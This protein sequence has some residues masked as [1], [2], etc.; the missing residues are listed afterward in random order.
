MT[1]FS[2]ALALLLTGLVLLLRL[3]PASGIAWLDAKSHSYTYAETFGLSAT[4]PPHGFEGRWEVIHGEAEVHGRTDPAATVSLKPGTSCLQWIVLRATSCSPQFSVREVS[5]EEV[6]RISRDYSEIH[7]VTRLVVPKA[8][9]N[10]TVDSPSVTLCATTPPPGMLGHWVVLRGGASLSSPFRNC[11]SAEGLCRGHNLFRYTILADPDI[12]IPPAVVR[13]TSTRGA[14]PVCADTDPEVLAREHEVE[15]KVRPA[16]KTGRGLTHPNG[17]PAQPQDISGKAVQPSESVRVLL[18]ETPSK[19]ASVLQAEAR[20]LAQAEAEEKDLEKAEALRLKAEARAEAVKMKAETEALKAKGKAKTNVVGPDTHIEPGRSS[21][22]PSHAEVIQPSERLPARLEETPSKFADMLE[23]ET[24]R[25]AEATAE[26]KDLLTAEA[27]LL[28]VEARTEAARMKAEA[29]A[30]KA[31]AKSEETPLSTVREPTPKTDKTK[32][33]PSTETEAREIAQGARE[34][35]SEESTQGQW[36][37]KVGPKKE[38]VS[39]AKAAERA[40]A[41]TQAQA[42]AE[43]RAKSQLAELEAEVQAEVLAETLVAEEAKVKAE[44]D[45]ETAELEAEAR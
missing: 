7:Y 38:E 14:S 11:T 27:A 43:A 8:G 9:P 16:K 21:A 29:A 6:E 19:V 25:L 26:E 20:F 3:P 31:K 40:R 45:A 36:K 30:L 18:K 32:V 33:M 41:R 12:A 10:R 39:L 22:A 24:R 1:S 44:V 2:V 37:S 5:P 42:E 17:A 13:V 28:D 34:K 35:A 15:Q 23:G 4:V